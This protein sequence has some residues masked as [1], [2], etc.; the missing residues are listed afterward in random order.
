MV[1]PTQN[2]SPVSCSGARCAGRCNQEKRLHG[3]YGTSCERE[4]YVVQS[5]MTRDLEDSVP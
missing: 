3:T 2:P 1:I 5:R 4:G